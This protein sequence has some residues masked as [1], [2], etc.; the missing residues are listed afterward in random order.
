[1]LCISSMRQHSLSMTQEACPPNF[2]SLT[3]HGSA[4]IALHIHRPPLVWGEALSLQAQPVACLLTNNFFF[5]PYAA[6]YR[7]LENRGTIH[8]W[9]HLKGNR[10]I[11]FSVSTCLYNAGFIASVKAWLISLHSPWSMYC[12]GSLTSS[13][14]ATGREGEEAGDLRLYLFIYLFNPSFSV[15]ESIT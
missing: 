14:A 4:F 2:S 13:M 1:M 9:L 8:D 6:S 10:R 7:K 12:N 3:H 11:V 5:F 15:Q